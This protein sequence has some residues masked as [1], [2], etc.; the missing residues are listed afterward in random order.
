MVMI[1]ACAPAISS[2]VVINTSASSHSGGVT[3]GQ[4][5]SV[6]TE[7]SESSVHIQTTLITDEQG[8]TAD[9]QIIN[10]RNGVPTVEKTHYD[11]PKGGAAVVHAATTSSAKARSS[12]SNTSAE[13]LATSSPA[14]STI[15]V[16]DL[17]S[18]DAVMAWLNQAPQS[19]VSII[20]RLFSLFSRR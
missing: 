17:R 5:E 8:G 19:F 1:S 3:A 6:A 18:E 14:S 20:K 7:S 11:I 2:A 13:T 4:G 10:T 9:V 16:K 12:V 15:S